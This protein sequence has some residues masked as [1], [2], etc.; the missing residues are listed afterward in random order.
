MNN[1]DISSTGENIQFN[2]YYSIDLANMFY[3]DFESENTRINFSRDNSLFL[4]GDAEKPFYKKAELE[5]MSKQALLDL[6]ID[7]GFIN[8]Y[9]HLKDYT[10]N[11]F[12]AELLPVT[13]KE[14]YELITKQFY[15]HDLRDKITH[16]FYISRGY[17]QGD[18]VYIVSIDKPID[19]AM[20]QYINQILWDCPLQVFCEVNGKEFTEDDFFDDYYSWD[21][22]LF[23]EKVKLLP[24]SDYAK[25]WIIENTPENPEHI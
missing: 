13:I 19:N 1:F 3:K 9:C 24:I 23:C 25:N 8:T 16:D 5:K 4:I 21:K 6:C 20:R 10:K 22:D 18:A 15:W 11:E 14:Y 12:I 17:S 2:V 7:F